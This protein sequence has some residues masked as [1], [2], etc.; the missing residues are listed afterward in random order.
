MNFCVQWKGM[1]VFFVHDCSVLPLC[2]VSH[3]DVMCLPTI[4]QHIYTALSPAASRAMET[5]EAR[6]NV[7]QTVFLILQTKAEPTLDLVN[8][9]HKIFQTLINTHFAKNLEVL[10][11]VRAYTLLM[12]SSICT[13]TFSYVWIY[14]DCADLLLTD[15]QLKTKVPRLETVVEVAVE[16]ISQSTY[17]PSLHGENRQVQLS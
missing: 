13:Y 3:R 6:L 8:I 7:M 4:K 9:A 15:I 11:F 17:S 10:T 5:V 2:S 1:H 16:A 14:G 12:A